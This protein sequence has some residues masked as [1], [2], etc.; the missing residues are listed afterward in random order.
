MTGWTRVCATSECLPGEYK[1]T[2]TSKETDNSQVI[3][4]IM[5]KGGGARQAEVGKATAKAMAER[6]PSTKAP[7]KRRKR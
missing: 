5:E 3:K 1:V 6:K 7:A 4:T 2:I